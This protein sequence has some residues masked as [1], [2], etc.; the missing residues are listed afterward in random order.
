MFVSFKVLAKSQSRNLDYKIIS[1]IKAIRSAFAVCRHR[2][3]LAFSGGK[4]STVLWHLIR[5]YFPEQSQRLVIIYGN[6]GVEFPECVR[7]AR[8]LGKEWGN[9]NFYEATPGHTESTG[10]KYSAQQEILQ[11]LITEG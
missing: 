8:Q 10:L 4:D 6:T 3:A 1:A 5:T 11:Y 9:G 7:F 2:P